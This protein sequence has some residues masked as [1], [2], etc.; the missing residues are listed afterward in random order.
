M[1]VEDI[2]DRVDQVKDKN[3][4]DSGAKT[5]A[6]VAGVIA[7]GIVGLMIGYSKKWNLFYSAVSGSFIGGGLGAILVPKTNAKK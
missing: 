5:R 1:F 4:K 2:L 6:I 7:G 3:G